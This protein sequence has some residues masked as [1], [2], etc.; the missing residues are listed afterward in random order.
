M[1]LRHLTTIDKIA[2]ILNDGFLRGSNNMR[3][4]HQDHVS[5]EIFNPNNDRFAFIKAYSLAKGA[6]INN[7]VE[8]FFDKEK[9]VNAGIEIRD[10]FIN[11]KK[12][13]KI[14]LSLY[15]EV[16]EDDFKSIGDYC[17]V[18]DKVPLEYLIEQSKRDI[19][20]FKER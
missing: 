6:N 19:Q 2:S 9:M 5:F 12:D 18:Y 13:N 10:S 11:G 20:Q 7:V 17:F 16:T 3:A 8:L 1:I 15:P 14:E 4:A